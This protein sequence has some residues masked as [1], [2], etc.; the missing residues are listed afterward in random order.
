LFFG[1]ARW[2]P[3]YIISLFG[4]R[5]NLGKVEKQKSGAGATQRL[6]FS[7]VFASQFPTVR[8][9]SDRVALHNTLP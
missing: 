6:F 7:P 3:D 9:M 1:K 4:S 8:V 2:D 5:P